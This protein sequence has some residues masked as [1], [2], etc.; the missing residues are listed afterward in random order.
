MVK[1]LLSLLFICSTVLAYAQQRPGSLRGTV[2]DAGTGQ[3]IP[4]PTILVK[5][6]SDRVVRNQD[7][8]VD[9]NY[10][11]NPLDPGTYNVEVSFTGYKTIRLEGVFIKPN[12][13]TI[14][15]FQLEVNPEL[16]DVIEIIEYKKPLI[17][18]DVKTTVTAEEI[19]E[20]AV[21]G[22][23]D[24]AAQTAGVYVADE[25][26]AP[27][28]RGSRANTT[29]NFIDGV[30]VRGSLQLP[31]GAIQQQEVYTGGMPA[32]YGDATGGII[33]T[34]TKG[35]SSQYFGQAEVLSSQ[36]FDPYN[37]NL[38]AFTA[39]GPLIKRKD[40]TKKPIMGFLTAIEFQHEHDPRPANTD[41]YQVRPELLDQIRQVPVRPAGT[42]QG[43]LANAEFV[44]MDDLEVI[45][46]RLNAG[47]YDI[48]V[49]NNFNFAI[50]EKTNFTLGGRFVHSRG[51]NTNFGQSLFNYDNY[52]EFIN[53]DLAVF[54]RITHSFT[55]NQT[56]G[57]G[58]ERQE[59]S[60]TNTIQNAFLVLQV[61]YT[62]NNRIVQDPR[63]QDNFFAYG[64]V[65]TF[66]RYSSFFYQQGTDATTGLQGWRAIAPQ[67]TM[68]AFTPSEHNPVLAA[69][70][71]YLYQAVADNPLLGNTRTFDAIRAFRG[72]LNGD[73]PESVYNGIWGNVGAVQSQ[74][75]DG[76]QSQYRQIRNSQFRISGSVTFDIKGHSLIVGGEYEQRFDRGFIV[77]GQG[78]WNQMR[79]LQ[80]D[81]I[82]EFDFDNPMPIYDEN[83][84]FQDTILYPRLFSETDWQQNAFTRRFRTAQGLDPRGLDFI[85]IDGYDPSEF[86]LGMF[87]ADQMINLNGSRLASFYGFDH[88]GQLLR[89]R[90]T[91]EDFFTQRNDD[92][93]LARPVGAF[94]PIYMALFVQ[95]Q[96]T[97]N[98]LR[99]NVGL[100]VDR[101]DA[102]QPVL[103]DPFLLYPA[104]TVDQLS[105]FENISDENVPSSIGRD[106][107]VYVSD[108]N[109]LSSNQE[110]NIVGYRSGR[111]WFGSDGSP[112]PNPKDIADAGGGS[113]R[114]LFFQDPNDLQLDAES[115]TDYTPQI[116]VMPRINFNFPVTDEALFF[117]HYD[118]LAQ[119]PDVALSRF[120]PIVMLEY[121]V[122][123]GTNNPISNPNLL[124]QRTTDYELGFTQVL[125]KRSSMKISGFY[126]EMRDM[127][128]TIAMVG[129]FPGNYIT[130]GNMDFSTVKGFSLEYDLRRY[131]NFTVFAN[132]TLQF[133]DGTGS[134]PNT[135]A[136]LAR[137]EQPNIR[138]ILPLSFDSRHQA[139]VRFDY[140]YSSGTSY[141]GPVW[142]DKQ[143]F[144]NAGVNFVL[145]ANS[146]T[147]YTRR[148][149][150]YPLTDNPSGAVP[151]QGQ[152]NGSRLPWQYRADMRINKSFVY[153]DLKK[154]KNIDV[155]IQILNVFNNRNVLNVYN[156]TG[157]ADDDGYITSNRARDVIAQSV[158]AQAF[159]DLY[160]ARMT[161]PFNFSLPRRV[162]LGIMW[163]F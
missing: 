145:N 146:G 110:P 130:Y 158:S 51:T 44:T 41:M 61:D 4:F 28:I 162:R 72:L 56:G 128:Q 112:L 9:G 57:R 152:I 150:A 54:G 123:K 43:V 89:G 155:Y 135:A 114:P 71:S 92:G 116:V 143:V 117:A 118:V 65:G 108:Y 141:D 47:Q 64:H 6:G 96:F 16:L 14:Q 154:G 32:Q 136:N 66:D 75:V 3:P 94:E 111:N 113:V 139:T 159:A 26:S 147:P 149:W 8:D 88:T 109:F 120:D 161:N 131:K 40:D 74:F 58:E 124:P 78:L 17:N 104:S 79:L 10:N 115:F 31:Q 69:Y 50:N 39:G 24:I 134:G 122:L 100:R 36:F 85:N 137:T 19:N 138:F 82:N 29:V 84:V 7:G 13:P 127:M 73:N 90:P 60:K 102:N 156:F 35:P 98:N 70:T 106:Y 22:I 103:K 34:T 99:F 87:S 5:D 11:I 18:T 42:G 76:V 148:E 95:D 33:A 121:E 2:K 25:G 101:Y 12:N 132:Y 93:T 45:P 52:L 133:A 160:T 59:E 30:K 63:H 67:D 163:T 83:G 21:R 86:S 107:T 62:R 144:A 140:R 151:V 81:H 38:F 129:A 153:G 46:A 119:R 91:I 48:R 126:R 1:K 27:V 49:T 125:T 15:N 20:M 53:T 68:I 55:G 157:A 105:Q 23:N 77:N 37:Y 97:F 80:N 142:W